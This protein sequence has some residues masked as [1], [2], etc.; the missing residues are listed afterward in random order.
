MITAVD[1]LTKYGVV[2]SKV[3]IILNSISITYVEKEN[4]L[5]YYQKHGDFELAVKSFITD[6][7]KLKEL[8]GLI[9]INNKFYIDFPMRQERLY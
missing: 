6:R 7:R 2:E 9:E 4:I 1:T 8:K 3:G 5:K